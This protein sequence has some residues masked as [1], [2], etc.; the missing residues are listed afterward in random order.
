MAFNENAVYR[1]INHMGR[2]L[3]GLFDRYPWFALLIGKELEEFFLMGLYFGE[4][5]FHCDPNNLLPD[6]DY[7]EPRNAVLPSDEFPEEVEEDEIDTDID[8]ADFE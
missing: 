4:R 3:R 5:R 1:S 6:I 7:P 2:K 8:D